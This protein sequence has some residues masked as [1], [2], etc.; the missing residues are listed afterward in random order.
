MTAITP[1]RLGLLM[2]G[3]K[4]NSALPTLLTKIGPGQIRVTD[5]MLRL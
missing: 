3:T 4:L 1:I 5:F 2:I